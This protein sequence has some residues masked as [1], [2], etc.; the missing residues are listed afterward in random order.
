MVMRMCAM[1]AHASA[2]AMDFSQSLASRRQ[3]PSQAKVRSTT[4]RRGRT[5]KPLAVSERLTPHFP[6]EDRFGRPW[7]HDILA[8]TM[9]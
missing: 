1:V 8:M 3:R 4:H 9:V 7:M 2:E 6:D 5:S